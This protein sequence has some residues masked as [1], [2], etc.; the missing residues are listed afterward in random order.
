MAQC[1][2]R[3]RE[4]DCIEICVQIFKEPRQIVERLFLK[5]YVPE[6][7]VFARSCVSFDDATFVVSSPRTLKT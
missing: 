1:W 6:F 3:E 7:V 2:L 5:L 4:N